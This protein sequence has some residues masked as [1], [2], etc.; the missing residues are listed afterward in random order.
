MDKNHL[1]N[2]NTPVTILSMRSTK[3]VCTI[4]P[5]CGEFSQLQQLADS[6]MNV[7]RINLSHGN[8]NVRKQIIRDI[9]KL[10]DQGN[11]CLAI[12]FDT[13]G[14][15]IR[16]GVV[17]HEIHIDKGE[18][19]VFS[20]LPLPE[21]KRTVILVNYDRFYADVPETD[22]IILDN[23]S[24]ILDIVRINEDG[25]VVAKSQNEG[26]I[27]SRRHITLPGAD[28]DLPSV[29][30]QD[31]K[32]LEFAVEQQA[33]FVALSF[34][35]TADE[36]RSVRSFL[37]EKKSDMHI[38][39]KI[40]T[41]QA[42]EQIAEI[43]EASDA[44]MIA[45]GDLGTD[46]PFEDLPSLQD[47]IVTRCR[48]KGLPVIVATHML[49][50]MIEHPTPT[51]AEV[52]DVAYAAMT[53]A[54]ATMLS[55]ETA[56]G[57]YPFKAVEAMHRILTKTETTLSRFHQGTMQSPIRNDREAR[58]DAAVILAKS[59]DAEALLVFTHTGRTAR[60]VSKFHPYIPII[61]LTD[62]PATQ[63]KLA[64]VYGVQPLL[65]AFGD[66]PESTVEKGM[67][68]A[69]EKGLIHAGQSVVLLSDT[70]AR[71]APVQSVQVREV[72]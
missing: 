28:I 17:Q 36:I 13:K 39:T 43:I 8:N 55:G 37:Q 59:S 27:G 42:T 15:E 10:N 38:I 61:A 45:R 4:G 3:I 30:E 20:S 63:R 60:D 56:T 22:R 41:R 52:T 64:L 47:E 6:G 49:E 1:F 65:L 67:H 40:E 70:E 5:A 24:M 58:A 72:A 7:A 16:T 14:A 23:G 50:S 54:S 34:I 35:R 11:Y 68:M 19:I 69:R 9:R 31:W 44:I 26:M 53:G 62:I 29:T 71:N 25:S 21:E 12:M 33:D 32:D 2:T 66:R 51:R 18:E 57:R 46:L 48:D